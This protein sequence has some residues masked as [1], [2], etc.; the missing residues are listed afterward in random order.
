MLRCLQIV[1]KQFFLICVEGYADLQ[2]YSLAVGN[3]AD[4]SEH[5]TCGSYPSPEAITN[6]TKY[7]VPCRDVGRY[8]SIK[9]TGVTDLHLVTL[10]EVIIV[11][12]VY[13]GD[14]T[15]GKYAAL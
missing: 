14:G 6:A 12:Y 2:F 4:V 7:V 8:V 11:G 3:D 1:C 5:I 15:S 13:N 9:R 10:C